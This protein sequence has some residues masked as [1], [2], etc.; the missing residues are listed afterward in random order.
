MNRLIFIQRKFFCESVSKAG[1]NVKDAN[2]K[3]KTINYELIDKE[4][5]RVKELVNELKSN[6]TKHSKSIFDHTRDNQALS[7][8]NNILQKTDLD[9]KTEYR[10]LA[11]EINKKYE[12]KKV[13]GTKDSKRTG[14]I[15]YKM[16]MTGLWD[17]WGIWF[18][19]TVIKIEN[20]QVTDV[21]TVEKNKYVALQLGVG[22]KEPSRVK[23]PIVGHLIK[24]DIPPKKDFKEFRVT[25]EN[26]LPIGYMLTV[27]HFVPGQKIDVSG[28]SIGKGWQG[29]MYKW[30][31]SGGFATHGCSLKH[32]G[33]VYT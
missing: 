31:F 4:R 5:L 28:T 11:D 3:Q 29:V 25:P 2:I 21:R 13:T 1:K 7:Y 8:I 12:I 19:L 20:C 23:K 10:N 32:R 6:P 16:G 24:N 27:R 30:N 18:P 9:K 26:I 33:A 15:G 14:I 22:N 17:K